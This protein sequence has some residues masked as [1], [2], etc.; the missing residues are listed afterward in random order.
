M[1]ALIAKLLAA[2]GA[3]IVIHYHGDK[4]A[5]DA[6]ALTARLK[7]KHPKIKTKAYQGDLSTA[8]SVQKLFADVLSDFG[9]LNTVVNTVGMV[10][11][12]PLIEISESG[13]RGYNYPLDLNF[14][15]QSSLTVRP[16]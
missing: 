4:A 7:E 1:G 14:R 10:L 3:N 12:K 2:E 6:E 11:K 9:K 15:G 13:R 8:K 5:K 16:Y